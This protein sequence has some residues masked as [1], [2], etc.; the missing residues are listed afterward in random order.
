MLRKLFGSRMQGMVTW[1][2]YDHPSRHPLMYP[3]MFV[4]RR[5]IGTTPTND[6]L[7]A[8]TH[9]ELCLKLPTGLTRRER[10]PSDDP[11]VFEVWSQEADSA[12]RRETR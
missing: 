1:V 9:R 8:G 6:L 10:L 5:W 12:D 7:T 2:V 11:D 4:A 3:D